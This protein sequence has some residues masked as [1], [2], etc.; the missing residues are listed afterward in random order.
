MPKTADIFVSVNR[1]HSLIS[2]SLYVVMIVSFDPLWFFPF[3]FLLIWCVLTHFF[4]FLHSSFWSSLVLFC[5]LQ[6]KTFHFH[7]IVIIFQI[8]EIFSIKFT[9]LS[10]S[11][12]KGKISFSIID[13]WYYLIFADQMIFVLSI[14]DFPL[15]YDPCP[16]FVRV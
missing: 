1:C 5:F 7:L 16:I 2:T 13:D 12:S 15:L 9:Y 11:H 4:L 14:I 6:N 8:S 10:N 3:Y